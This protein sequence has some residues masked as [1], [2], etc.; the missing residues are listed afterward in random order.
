MD[1]NMQNYLSHMYDMVSDL[2]DQSLYENRRNQS[3]KNPL[4]NYGR[5]GF[6]QTDEDGITQE[7]IRRIGQFCWPD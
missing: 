7:I 6:S 1:E 3:Y 2:R 4:N 5:K